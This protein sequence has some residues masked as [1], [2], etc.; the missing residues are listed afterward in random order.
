MTF[1]DNF[2]QTLQLLE[3]VVL[4]PVPPRPRPR[5]A[6]RAGGEAGRGRAAGAHQARGGGGGGAGGGQ[7]YVP[8]VPDDHRALAL[9]RLV[10][11]V[12]GV[13][14]GAGLARVVREVSRPAQD[15][16][17]VRTLDTDNIIMQLYV[18]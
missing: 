3:P 5:L 18:R 4:R 13:E 9:W 2:P 11:G 17:Y 15:T 6:V 16:C 7:G 14:V 12:V 1:H 10:E 8:V